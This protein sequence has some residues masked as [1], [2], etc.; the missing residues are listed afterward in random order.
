RDIGVQMSIDDFGTGHSS[1]VQLKRLPVNQIKIDKSF[2]REMTKNE[3]DAVIVRSTIE[4]GH[5]LGLS[6]V[7]E[8][9]EDQATWD[10]LTALGCDEGQGFLLSPGVPPADLVRWLAGWAAG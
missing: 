4:L 2:V 1:L 7:A 9:V 5:N 3:N 10:A 8:G 6:V